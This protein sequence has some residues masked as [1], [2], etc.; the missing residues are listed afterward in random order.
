MVQLEEM[1]SH[2]CIMEEAPFRVCALGAAGDTHQFPVV[3]K[4]VLRVGRWFP[5][6]RNGASGAWTV[7][8]D[9]LRQ[10]TK[11]FYR[12]RRE[13]NRVPWIW[14]HDGGAKERI[15]DVAD[16]WVAGD[17]LYARC[18][19]TDKAHQ[20]SFGAKTGDETA[21]EVS[22]E[23][24]SNWTDGKGNQYDLAL[25]H[26]A[27]VINPVV[28]DQG[29][30]R[31]LSLKGK[32]RMAKEDEGA[33]GG[34]DASN[35]T[36]AE[37]KELLQ[38]AGVNLPDSATTKEAIVAVVDSQSVAPEAGADDAELPMAIDNLAPEQMTPS[39]LSLALRRTRMSLAG[40]KDRIS[41]LEKAGTDAQRKSFES[42]LDSLIAAGD[43]KPAE[44]DE[45]L[46]DGASCSFRL[47]L[48]ERLRGRAV[49]PT[50]NGRVARL[51]ATAAPPG[52][53]TE[54]QQKEEAAKIREESLRRMGLPKRA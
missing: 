29:P 48:L 36:L 1:G 4:D 44:K 51:G 26:L 17:A 32:T 37:V 21:H 2:C 38:K 9:T 52:V 53:L 30:F 46:A 49:V 3:E 6:G 42:Q 27:V 31:R 28:T 15:G 10:L 45:I 35:W 19:V 22:V 33:E 14:E 18:Q 23:V 12:M 13:G 39:Q 20:F 25:T 24:S 8:R 11:N 34:S 40:A 54:E 16:L 43:V 41:A 7:T 5:E 50:A 47:S